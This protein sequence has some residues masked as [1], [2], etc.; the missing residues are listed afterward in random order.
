[1]AKSGHLNITYFADKF[2]PGSRRILRTV[3]TGIV[4]ITFTLLAILGGIMAYDEYRF[5]VASPGLGIPT[6]IYTVWMPVLCLA[7]L[8]RAIGLM[9]RIWRNRE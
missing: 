5:E 3:T 2:S 8:G 4:A 1:M 7:I 9:L 6:W